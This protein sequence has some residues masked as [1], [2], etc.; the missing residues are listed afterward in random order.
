MK[1]VV[2]LGEVMMR[3]TPTGMDRLVQANAFDAHLGGSEFNVA[4]GLHSLGHDTKFVTKLPDNDTGRWA[5]RRI[6]A[7]GVELN[8]DV[9]SPKGR[10]GI[11]FLEKG[12]SPRPYKVTYDR[13]GSSISLAQPQE[14]DWGRSFANAGWFHVSGITPALSEGMA[15]ATEQAIDAAVEWKIPVSIDL[16]YRAKLWTL[17]EARTV[18]VPLIRKAKVLLSTEDDLLQVFGLD[19]SRPELCAD[20]ARELLGVEYVAVTHR[21]MTTVASNRWGGCACGPEGFKHS[22]YYDIDMIDRV[23]AGDAFT[24]GFIAGMLHDDMELAL[25]L[26]SAFSALKQTI[27]GDVCLATRAEVDALIAAGSAGKI[28]R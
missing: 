25:E 20:K 7:C 21:E 14:F 24:A 10:L 22:A 15:K 13:A 9:F 18:L 1:K 17:D 8:P 19:S 3:L 11:Y 27:P 2:T 23:G 28:Q 6:R 4:A 16:N 5:E 12:A 26:A